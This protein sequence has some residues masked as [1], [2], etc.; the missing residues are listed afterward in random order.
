M[1]RGGGGG[2]GGGIMHAEHG[3]GAPSCD[4]VRYQPPAIRKWVG[5]GYEASNIHACI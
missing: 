3:G 2:G 1:A 4:V 5:P